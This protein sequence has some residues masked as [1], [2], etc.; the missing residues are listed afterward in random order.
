VNSTLTDTFR[1][2]GFIK[3]G[4]GRK[5]RYTIMSDMVINALEDY[6]SQYNTSNWLF[7]GAEP[8]KR[9]SIRSA[10][11]FF[12]HS[13][14]KAGIVKPA[15]I[16]SLRH[17]S[18]AHLLENGT[19][20]RYIQELLGHSS[21]RTAERCTHVARQSALKIQSPLDTMDEEE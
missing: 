20:I 16:H 13:I 1:N 4:K 5:D 11:Y 21:L 12:E 14:T 18:A 17:S 6:Y 7:D 8:G 10:Q 9:L 2:S 19:G 3:S 15:S